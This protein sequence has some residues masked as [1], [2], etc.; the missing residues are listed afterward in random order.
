M[1][2]FVLCSVRTASTALTAACKHI[3]N[4]TSA[5]ESRVNK[6]SSTKLNYPDQHIEIDNSLI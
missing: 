2:V 4:Y 6:L 3:T 5:H 1:N